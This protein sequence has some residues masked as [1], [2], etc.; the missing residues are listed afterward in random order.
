MASGLWR[1]K[2]KSKGSSDGS[3]SQGLEL[4]ARSCLVSLQL[5][6]SNPVESN[7]MLSR[8]KHYLFPL[9]IAANVTQSATCQLD[10]VLLTFGRLYMEFQKLDESNGLVWSKIT[11]R[12]R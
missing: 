2:G 10:D 8:I 6:R 1:C 4:L 12:E 3:H 5:T 11:A 7:D 9:A